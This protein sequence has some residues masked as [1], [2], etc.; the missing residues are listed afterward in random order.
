MSP[1][2][3]KIQRLALVAMTLS[4]YACGTAGEFS[5]IQLLDNQEDISIP[6]ESR[7]ETTDALSLAK[8]SGTKCDGLS[9][10]ATTCSTDAIEKAYKNINSAMG[11]KRGTLKVWCSPTCGTLW[12]VTRTTSDVRSDLTVSATI[13]GR[14]TSRS[15]SATG[16]YVTTMLY[17]A[18]LAMSAKGTI[19]DF[20]G[21]VLEESIDSVTCP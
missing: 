6:H 4:I 12:A 2:R 5:N 1:Q 13:S 19:T 8:C 11:I 17:T 18:G 21:T 7:D 10:S 14:G 15:G 9:A 16:K 3:A 20:D